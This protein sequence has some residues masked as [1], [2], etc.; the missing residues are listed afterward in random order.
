MIQPKRS[1]G[2]CTVK[3]NAAVPSLPAQ[4]SRTVNSQSPGLGSEIVAS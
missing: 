4:W 2:P 1:G 3:L